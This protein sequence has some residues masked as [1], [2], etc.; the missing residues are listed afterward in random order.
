[1]AITAISAVV[2]MYRIDYP[3]QVVW[4]STPLHENTPKWTYLYINDNL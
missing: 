2:R 4:V 1:L 3:P